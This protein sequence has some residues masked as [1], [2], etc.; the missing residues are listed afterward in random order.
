MHKPNSR[1]WLIA[2]ATAGAIA[3]FSAA[4]AYGWIGGMAF[5]ASDRG[6]ATPTVGLELPG[7][8]AACESV[9]GKWGRIGIALQDGC[10]LPTSDA[11]RVCANSTECQGLCIAD[12]SQNDYDRVRYNRV[13]I[14]TQGQC[15]PW[16]IT[17]GCVPLVRQGLVTQILC[18]D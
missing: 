15:A 4:I 1:P 18:L 16:R 2:V 5:F 13:A 3:F 11:G 6:L 10:N 9:G 17:V 7:D 8:K 14:P 12:L